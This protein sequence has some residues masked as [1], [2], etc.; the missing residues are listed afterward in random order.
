MKLKVKKEGKTENYNLINSWS[1]VNLEKWGKLLSIKSKDNSVDAIETLSVLTDMPK[2]I[3]R[4]LNLTDVSKILSKVAEMQRLSDTNLVRVIEIDGKEYG[5]HPNLDEITLGEYADIET[6]IKDG[7]MT[8]NLPELMAILYRPIT[9]KKNDIYSIEAY[10]GQIEIRREIMKGMKG[11]QVQSAL[12]FFWILGKQFLQS[13]PLYLQEL[14]L[15]TTMKTLQETTSEK[16]G[17]GLE[18]SIV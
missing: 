11:E 12:V 18:S 17:V 6:L 10:D 3:I 9:E 14:S 4:S 7:N 13:I 1:E 15:E 5:F 2:K 16:G 8:E